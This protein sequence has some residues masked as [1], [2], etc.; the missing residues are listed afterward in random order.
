MMVRTL[1]VGSSKKRETSAGVHVWC[2]PPHDEPEAVAGVGAMAGSGGH[3]E[4][5][6]IHDWWC[7]PSHD[8]QE[9]VSSMGEVAVHSC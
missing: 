2:S 8:E 5:A 7:D 9:A 4:G 3:F 6:G 1:L